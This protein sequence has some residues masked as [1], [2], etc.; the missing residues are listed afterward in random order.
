MRAAGLLGR[1]VKWIEDRLEN[2]RPPGR[3]ARSASTW[4]SRY[5]TDGTVRRFARGR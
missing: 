3:H 1:P 5:D 2:L 4:R